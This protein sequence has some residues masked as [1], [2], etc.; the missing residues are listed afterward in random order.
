M[1]IK[2]FL[3]DESGAITVDWVVLTAAVV[4]L[5]AAVVVGIA[6]NTLNLAGKV[7]TELESS[8]AM[9]EHRVPS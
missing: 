8:D 1:R 2:S 5:G 9:I 6:T 4:L 3:S 7:G